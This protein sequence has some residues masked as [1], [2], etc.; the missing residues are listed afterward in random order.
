MKEG[1]KNEYWETSRSSYHSLESHYFL[2]IK[3]F[4]IP[5]DVLKLFYR[6]LSVRKCLPPHLKR[7]VTID[8]T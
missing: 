8:L 2:S 6:R 3:Y 5:Q 7:D 1:R 4:N